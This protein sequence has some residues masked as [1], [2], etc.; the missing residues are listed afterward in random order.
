MSVAGRYSR[1]D[2]YTRVLRI[3]SKP[4]KYC[5]NLVRRNAVY[6]YRRRVPQD[7]LAQLG[8]REIWQSLLTKDKTEAIASA[9][10]LHMLQDEEWAKLR[11][12]EPSS[13]ASPV[14]LGGPDLAKL[15]NDHIRFLLSRDDVIRQNLMPL[16][17]DLEPVAAMVSGP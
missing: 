3:V 2:C 15:A 4:L 5:T 1:W 17:P 12:P 10:A 11:S 9:R 13:I 14:R 6:Y 8:K 16:L 7:L